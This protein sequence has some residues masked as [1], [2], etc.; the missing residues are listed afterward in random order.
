VRKFAVEKTCPGIYN[1][2]GDILPIQVIESQKLSTDDNLWLNGLRRRLA[3]S[4][5]NHV[6]EVLGR[7]GKGARVN[8][9]LEAITQ[10]NA[11][12]LKEIYKMRKDPT[13]EEVLEEVGIVEKYTAIGEKK[14]K[15]EEQRRILELIEKGL[16]V[17]EI[18]ASLN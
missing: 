14:G 9:Y 12:I 3:P 10:A 15:A 7:Q 6:Y 2:T 1:I 16:T 17:E 11:N 8:A 5:V 13:F 4:V 18:K